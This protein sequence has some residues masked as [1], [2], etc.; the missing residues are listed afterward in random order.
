MLSPP[1]PDPLM[2]ATCLKCGEKFV[3][4]LVKPELNAA[5]AWQPKQSA[6]FHEL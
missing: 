1:P 6:K 2:P 5:S 4:L 3:S